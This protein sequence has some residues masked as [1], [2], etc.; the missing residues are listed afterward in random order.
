MPFA[1]MSMRS[2][3]STMTTLLAI[4]IRQIFQD[5]I[6]KGTLN[7]TITSFTRDHHAVGRGDDHAEDESVEL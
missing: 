2:E 4:H 3:A 7:R 5:Q 1:K 6:E